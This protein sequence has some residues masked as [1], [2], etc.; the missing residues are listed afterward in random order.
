MSDARNY[1][2]ITRADVGKAFLRAFG[3]VW[4]MSAVLGRVL[5]QDVG[6]RLYRVRAEDG[7]TDI[8]QAENEPQRAA[9]LA[10]EHEPERCHEIVHSW[11]G[12]TRYV[13]EAERFTEH[14]H[15]EPRPYLRLL[16]DDEQITEPDAFGCQ[17]L[18]PH[19]AVASD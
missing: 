16:R 4:P 5:D 19:R 9:R 8:L 15:G 3:R 1:Y 2:T 11:A 18:K 14:L 10:R 13:C 7:V 6:K 12:T 17:F